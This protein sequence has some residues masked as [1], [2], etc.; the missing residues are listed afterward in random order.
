VSVERRPVMV[1]FLD[2][3]GRDYGTAFKA[4]GSVKQAEFCILRDVI[5]VHGY[6]VRRLRYRPRVVA[7]IDRKLELQ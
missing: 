4:S 5:D 7:P 3:V 6:N 2:S 1:R